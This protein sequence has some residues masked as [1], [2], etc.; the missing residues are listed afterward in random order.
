[1]SGASGVSRMSSG[2]SM[3]LIASEERLLWALGGLAVVSLVWLVVLA[4]VWWRQSRWDVP[5][6]DD[7]VTPLPA[8]CDH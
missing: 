8:D 7:G 4:V 6:A 3:I 5:L 1:M 2:P